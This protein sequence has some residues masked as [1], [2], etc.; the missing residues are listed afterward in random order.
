MDLS[1]E[2]LDK[3]S[4]EVHNIRKSA[5]TRQLNMNSQKLVRK[6]KK[7]YEVNLTLF[8]RKFAIFHALAQLYEQKDREQFFSQEELKNI[9]AYDL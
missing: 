7:L 9:N 4:L 8:Y 5:I 2:M 6:V 1:F 3:I